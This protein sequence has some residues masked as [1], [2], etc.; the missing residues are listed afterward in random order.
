MNKGMIRHLLGIVIMIE[1]AVMLLPALVALIYKENSGVWFLIV[2]AGSIIIGAALT[3]IKRTKRVK[4]Y[5]KEGFVVVA[6]SWI[7]I[8]I[9]GA[10]PFCLSGEI[11]FFIDALFESSSG[12]TTTGASVVNDVEALS[13]CMI[14]WRSLSIWIGGMGFLVFLMAILPLAGGSQNMHLMRA[15]SPGPQVGKFIPRLRGT[16]M[17]LYGIYM[18]LTA[19]ELILLLVGGMPLFD[20]IN[21]AMSTAGTGGFAITNAG[22]SSYTSIY[23]QAVIA[24]FMVIF[25]MNFSFQFLILTRRWKQLLH[26]EEVWWYLGIIL[27]STVTITINLKMV[28]PE[29]PNAF[30]DA[31][32]Q[33]SSLMTSTG[34][35]NANYDLW[36]AL[37]QNI[38]LI[39][40]C[41]GACAG[42]TGG[43]FKVSRVIILLKYS[44][45]S[46]SRALHPRNVKVVKMDGKKIDSTVVHTTSGYLAIYV[47]FMVFSVL[48]LSIN[49][50]DFH[51]TL[52]AVVATINNTGPGFNL[53]GPTHTFSQFSPFS[54]VVLIINMIAGRLEFFPMLFLFSPSVWR[55]K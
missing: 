12:F 38:L 54:K 23:L 52:S 6:L 1:G 26:L 33:V 22:I 8:S 7:V 19:I 9:I 43:G 2:G 28:Y 46:L 47:C 27:L 40:M 14:F 36:P 11:P 44:S 4:M 16:A 34:F 50:F 21:I 29:M 20:A 41:V 31:F 48:L 45:K 24:I 15:E 53:V 35:S 13:N 32:F 5:A 18:L 25:G 51:T 55:N 49:G 39:L 10:L 37:S 3:F 30:H 42:S 17:I